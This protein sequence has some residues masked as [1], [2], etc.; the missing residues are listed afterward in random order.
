MAQR[1]TKSV[2]TEQAV[3]QFREAAAKSTK[4]ATKSQ[5]AARETLIALGSHTR[6]GK[7]TAK[8]KK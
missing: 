6:T 3:S 5:K 7:L 4:R 8:Y 1:A 2:T